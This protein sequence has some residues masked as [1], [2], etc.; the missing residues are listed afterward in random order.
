MPSAASLPRPPPAR[1]RWS[2]PWSRWSSLAVVLLAVALDAGPVR[3]ITAARRPVG[4]HGRRRPAG[5]ATCR[6]AAR[7]RTPACP[8]VAESALPDE[9]DTTLALI[10]AGGP[11]PYEEDGGG[12]RQP[13]ADP[14]PAAERLL[15]RVHRRDTR[16]KATAGRAG[17]S[18]G[19]DGDLYWTTDHYASFRQIEEGR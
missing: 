10:R 8:T 1:R 12:L 11:F 16:V 2:W 19:A 7:R 4:E 18:A 17:S 14:A 9:A 15:P 6:A 13:R 5:S 3:R